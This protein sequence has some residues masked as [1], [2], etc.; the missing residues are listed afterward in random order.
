MSGEPLSITEIAA[1]VQADGYSS[2][3]KNFR[4]YLRAKIRASGYYTEDSKGRWTLIFS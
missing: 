2:E 3:A 1:R 4:Q